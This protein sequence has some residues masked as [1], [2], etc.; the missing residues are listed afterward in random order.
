[1][2]RI[3]ETIRACRA[4]EEPNHAAPHGF[5]VKRLVMFFYGTKT[6]TGR[7]IAEVIGKAKKY[8]GHEKGKMWK[9]KKPLYVSWLCDFKIVLEKKNDSDFKNDEDWRKLKKPL[10]FGLET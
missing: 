9:V 8:C 3:F 2:K 4:N 6:I 10:H 7:S 5:R 1:M